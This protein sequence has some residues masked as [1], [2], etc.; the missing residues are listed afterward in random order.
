M[1]TYLYDDRNS[2]AHTMLGFAV[3]FLPLLIGLAATLAFLLYEVWE[4]ENPVNTVGDV[5]E[6][7]VGFVLGLYVGTKLGVVA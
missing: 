7:L 2:L 6:F 3:P 1:K 4:K 5:V